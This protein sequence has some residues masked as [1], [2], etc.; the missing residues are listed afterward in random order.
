MSHIIILSNLN[1][2][3]YNRKYLWSFKKKN[4]IIITWKMDQFDIRSLVLIGKSS[5]ESW[6]INLL[7]TYCHP[8]YFSWGILS[9]CLVYVA[10]S[11]VLYCKSTIIF[12]FWNIV[13]MSLMWTRPRSFW[14][15]KCLICSH[16]K[17]GSSLT[18]AWHSLSTW[19]E[20][21]ANKIASKYQLLFLFHVWCFLSNPW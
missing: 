8:P 13:I 10:W 1:K 20:T 16:G 14:F 5:S 18:K 15:W 2:I 12:T 3:I 6:K 9:I 11:R 21:Q 19:N 7:A 17:R 4:I